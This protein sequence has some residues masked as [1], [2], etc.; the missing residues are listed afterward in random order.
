[1]KIDRLRIDLDDFDERLDGLVGLLVQQEIQAAKVRQRQRARLTQQMLDVDARGDPSHAR[2][3]APESASSHQ[4]SKS[5]ESH[6][7][8]HV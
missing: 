4:S 5:M 8:W 1:M 7:R 6:A 3:T 2:R